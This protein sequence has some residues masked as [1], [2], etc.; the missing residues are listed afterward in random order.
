MD[1]G[2][3]PRQAAAKS[4][5]QDTIPALYTPGLDG[6]RQRDG[7]RSGGG[8]ATTLQ[9]QEELLRFGS[10][11]SGKRLDETPVRLVGDD[12]IYISHREAALTQSIF[13]GT[14]KHG[15]GFFEYPRAFYSQEVQ[16]A[17]NRVETGRRP[18]AARAQG[19]QANAGPIGSHARREESRASNRGTCTPPFL[20]RSSSRG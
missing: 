15:H 1:D 18:A 16:S 3:T 8:V 4:H 5:E 12:A 7:N 10:E 9:V 6:S 2:R 11:S 17:C 13:G 19:E 14:A 20:E